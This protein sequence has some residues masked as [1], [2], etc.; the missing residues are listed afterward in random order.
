[1]KR[2]TLVVLIALLCG[3]MVAPS[4]MPLSAQDAPPT[5]PP[6]PT[7]MPRPSPSFTTTVNNAT[8]AALFPDAAAGRY[9]ADARHA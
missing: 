8:L 7:Q 9:R 6:L 4:V 1:M 3:L 2:L 5:V